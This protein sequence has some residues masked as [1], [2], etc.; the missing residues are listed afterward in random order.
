VALIPLAL[1]A[2]STEPARRA[3]TIPVELTTATAVSLLDQKMVVRSTGLP[4]GSRTMAASET[5]NPVRT[6]TRSGRSSID[7][8]CTLLS[9]T[10]PPHATPPAPSSSATSVRRAT[11]AGPRAAII[12]ELP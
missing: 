12:G 3:V 11:R 4:A 5:V 2:T 6:L 8:T 10:P 1:A 7:P 9:V